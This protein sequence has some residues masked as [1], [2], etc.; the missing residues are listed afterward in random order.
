MLGQNKSDIE[1]QN[2]KNG[3]NVF[4]A[5]VGS[6]KLIYTNALIEMCKQKRVIL[7]DLNEDF[8][9]RQQHLMKIMN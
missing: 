2:A 9:Q 8:E 4:V 1:K 5:Q 6:K 7:V 3:S